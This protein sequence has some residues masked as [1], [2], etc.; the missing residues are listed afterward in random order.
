MVRL[1][2]EW[3]GQMA[4]IGGFPIECLAEGTRLEI[5]EQVKAHCRRLGPGGGYVLAT[6]ASF[7][8]AVP[9][10]NLLV[11]AQAIHKYGRF[12]LLKQGRQA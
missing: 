3:A 1:K 2:E 12:E 5:E 10:E 9:P 11:L 8:G 7:T 4:F 6:T